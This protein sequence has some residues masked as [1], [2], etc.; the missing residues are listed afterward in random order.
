M[1]RPNVFIVGVPRCGTTSLYTYLNRHPA[2]F[3]SACKE[4]EFFATDLAFPHAI[5]NEKAYLSLF[6]EAADRNWAGE[7]S[8]FYLFSKDAPANICRLSPQAR[9]VA[10]IRNP[11]EQIPS[12][13]NM[14]LSVHWEGCE[15]QP[16]LET[17]LD[18]EQKRKHGRMLPPHNTMPPRLTCT[19]R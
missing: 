11:V 14:L 10:L 13:H 9:T 19:V 18:L 15:D 1:K 3:M 17:A 16:D 5:R 2:V 4:P 12:Y 6:A 7:A 8:T